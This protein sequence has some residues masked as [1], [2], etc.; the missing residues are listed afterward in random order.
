MGLAERVG[1][2]GPHCLQFYVFLDKLSFEKRGEGA[3]L[4]DSCTARL[5]TSIRWPGVPPV[6]RVLHAE[7]TSLVIP[8]G[9]SIASSSLGKDPWPLNLGLSFPVHLL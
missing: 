8:L 5:T 4:S 7:E 1:L 2:Q 9:P 6:E 3:Q